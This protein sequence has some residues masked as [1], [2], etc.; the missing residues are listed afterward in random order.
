MA[1]SLPA[2]KQ[3]MSSTLLFVSPKPVR[4]GAVG[5]CPQQ[6]SD[7]VVVAGAAGAAEPVL[8]AVVLNADFG[9]ALC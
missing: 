1:T 5:S 6:S 3:T 4:A 8:A 2:M 9:M 7:A